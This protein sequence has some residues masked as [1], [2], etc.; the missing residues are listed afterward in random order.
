M[1]NRSHVVPGFTLSRSQRMITFLSLY[2]SSSFRRCSCSCCRRRK[3]N[4]WS[5]SSDM[6]LDDDGDEIWPLFFRGAAALS[7]SWTE[8][9][10]EEREE[11]E[12]EDRKRKSLPFLKPLIVFLISIV[13][14]EERGREGKSVDAKKADMRWF[15]PLQGEV[16]WRI[17]HS[18]KRYL[19]VEKYIYSNNWGCSKTKSYVFYLN[20]LRIYLSTYLANT[21]THKLSLSLAFSIT[22]VLLL[23]LLLLQKGVVSRALSLSSRPSPSSLP[24]RCTSKRHRRRFLSP[25]ELLS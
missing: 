8:E 6:V 23:L 15:F 14:A 1:A 20:Y 10:E 4:L 16:K 22:T 25:R 9:E 3:K 5:F 18:K 7:P 19:R 11:E 17:L 21:H 2:S 12:R 24:P 13:D